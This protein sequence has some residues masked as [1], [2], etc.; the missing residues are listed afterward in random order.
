V[1]TEDRARADRENRRHLGFERLPD[2]A[3][4][5]DAPADPLEP[6]GL[7]AAVDRAWLHA[8]FE[9]LVPCHE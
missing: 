3:D 4:P 5:I 1:V 7:E 2:R 8:K 9:E 6:L